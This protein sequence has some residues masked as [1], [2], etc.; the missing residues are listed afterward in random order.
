MSQL[1]YCTSCSRHFKGVEVACPFCGVPAREA[2]L[3]ARIAPRGASR[4][5]V[6]VASASML[7]S[8]VFVACTDGAREQSSDETPGGA[9]E[10]GDSVSDG[11]GE[12]SATSRENTPTSASTASNSSSDH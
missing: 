10:S 1:V 9:T 5:K 2:Q 6:Y 12:Q 8:A 3:K 11:T 7:V 4:S